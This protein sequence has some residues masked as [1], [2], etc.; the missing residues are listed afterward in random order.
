MPSKHA[1]TD[2]N[3]EIS[4]PLPIRQFSY[5]KICICKQ[6]VKILAASYCFRRHSDDKL[7]F[8]YVSNKNL[9]SQLPMT[10]QLLSTPTVIC[11]YFKLVCCRPNTNTL[12]TKLILQ[13]STI[14]HYSCS[15]T[16][17][18]LQCFLDYPG[19]W[20]GRVHG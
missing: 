9:T 10:L 11:K 18:T 2:T 14:S 15:L 20:W 16:F 8:L 12:S 1:H 6:E 4:N 19:Y 7:Q 5:S 17:N 13:S 3:N